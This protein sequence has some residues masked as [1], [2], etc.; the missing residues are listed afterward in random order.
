[1]AQQPNR[2]NVYRPADAGVDRLLS[3]AEFAELL[4]TAFDQWVGY[5]IR[6]SI[7][8]GNDLVAE[9]KSDELPDDAPTE[10]R[11]LLA[12]ASRSVEGRLELWC[13][14]LMG[15][16][17]PSDEIVAEL[18]DLV[19][20]HWGQRDPAT[21]L[22]FLKTPSALQGF[23]ALVRARASAGAPIAVLHLDLDN[24]KSIN[25]IGYEVGNDVLR[26]FT[27]RFRSA[28][29][30]LGVPVRTGGDEL[31]AILY[32]GTI[33]Q[34]L[35][36][37]D[38]F[39]RRMHEEPF[40]AINRPNTCSIG[41]CLYPIS[42][43]FLGVT[44][45][46]VIL[47][48]AIAAAERAKVEG[49][50]RVVLSGPIKPVA[51]TDT[52]SSQDL[53]LAALATRRILQPED[54][55]D[56]DAFADIVVD[57]LANGL[58]SL[59][60]I[61]V[62]IQKVRDELGLLVGTYD[63]PP[64]RPAILQGVVDSLT[65][66]TWVGQAV[67]RAAFRKTL[68][69]DPASILTLHSSPS[70]GLSLKID[71]LTIPLNASASL[72]AE[73]S[74][75]IGKPFYAAGD[76]P[77]GGVGRRV[78]SAPFDAC[79]PMSP[80]LLLAIGDEARKL[81]VDLRRF[82][83]AVVEIDDRPA[84]GG[85]LP[86]FWQSNVARVVRAC[87]KNANITTI[88]AIGDKDCAQQTLERLKAPDSQAHR[89]ELQSRLSLTPAKVEALQARHLCIR[90]VAADCSDVL[91]EISRAVE[92]LEALDFPTRSE[93]DP[94]NE[95]SKRRLPIASP[96]ANRRL[97]LTDGLQTRALA[98][99]YPEAVHLIRG[100]D[101]TFDFLETSRGKFRE[102]TGFKIVLTEPLSDMVPDYWRSERQ[103]LEEY[104]DRNFRHVEGL[105]GKRLQSPLNDAGP[106]LIEFAIEQ[107]VEA[108]LT[109]HPTRRINLPISPDDLRQ[110]LGLSTI[111]VLPRCRGEEQRL[112]VLFVWRTVD[113][114][115]GFPFSGY[116]SISWA[117]DFVQG[118]NDRLEQRGEAIRVNLGTLTYIALSFHMY[119][120]SGD[121]EI[122]RTIVQD[123][124]R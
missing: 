79:D 5:A 81:A 6:L 107:T 92:I 44:S 69:L 119:L 82:A 7:T 16:R 64:D 93:F 67:L 77:T 10:T 104:Y 1:M 19:D 32:G 39:R 61:S 118:V 85:G 98:D 37:T 40:A 63:A 31:S 113:A 60:G 112:D 80:V 76:E 83:G 75:V 56:P 84:R 43:R 49:R 33:A 58:T 103:S 26:E 90:E 41:L 55:N 30:G 87:L 95:K 14:P 4:M 51:A 70:G 9:Y 38:A 20:R 73:S 124:S 8:S 22:P 25:T 66:S 100:A 86:D 2:S 71:Q 24:F 120:H 42:E 57:R 15:A 62:A 50:N 110:P 21:L 99:A 35:Q 111:Q 121:L 108:L 13:T 123:A 96:D 23:I 46:K 109:V 78:R 3:E 122:A 94:T 65:W 72:L 29:S 89:S 59:D 97:A 53:A 12:D 48:D 102:F 28:F 47:R 11:P 17:T 74:A 18:T 52:I 68:P 34:I 116:G 88:I 105:F 45:E 115:V 106:T 54:A 117:R 101:E 114:L 36:A 27:E 91:A